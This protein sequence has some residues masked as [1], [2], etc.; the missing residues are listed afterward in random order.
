MDKNWI[1]VSLVAMRGLQC[2]WEEILRETR[3]RLLKKSIHTMQRCTKLW[4]LPVKTN[5][6]NSI[7]GFRATQTDSITN[8][9]AQCNY[10]MAFR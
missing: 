3:T 6:N 1:R 4:T 10:Q 5:T 7:S 9:T 2:D 8:H